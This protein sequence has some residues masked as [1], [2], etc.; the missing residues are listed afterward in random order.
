VK[1][2]NRIQKQHAIQ[3]AKKQLGKPFQGEW[4]NKNFD[5]TDTSNDSLANN[6]YCSELIWAAYYNC[7]QNFSGNKLDN[8]FIYGNGIDIDFNEWANIGNF[9]IVAPRDMLWD[10]DVRRIFPRK[11][12]QQNTILLFQ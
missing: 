2:A 8:E 4:I 7:N 3:F 5:P 6:W 1:T 12:C 11:K 10:D 9:T